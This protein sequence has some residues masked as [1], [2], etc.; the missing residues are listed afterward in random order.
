MI[1]KELE[2][3][4]SDGINTV[5]VIGN[6][7]EPSLSRPVDKENIINQL[8]KLGNT[9]FIVEDIDIEMN[10][11]IFV[12]L[13]EL[14]ELRRTLVERLIEK[15]VYISKKRVNM[16]TCKSENN[17]VRE[18]K[19]SA[20]V[21]NEEQLLTAL[22]EDLD[23][24]YITDINLYNKYNNNE[25]VYLRTDRVTNNFINY[26]NENILATELGTINKYSKDNNVCCDYYLNVNNNFSIKTLEKLGIKRICLSPEI[27]DFDKINSNIDIEMIIYGRL[28]LMITKYCPLNTLINKDD[29][30]C[31]LCLN[32]DRYYLK[33]DKNRRYPLIHN[34]HITHIMHHKNLNLFNDVYEYK[35]RG[36]NCF[37]LELFDENKDEMLCLISKLKG[38]LY[39]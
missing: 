35:N 7:I 8:F 34:K 10:N 3:S 24:I 17:I 6:K 27:K 39:E 20:L 33:D 36:V 14:N 4:I 21:R 15:R 19:I 11:N 32:K 5:T 12:S 1:D 2:I 30:K 22:K 26:S 16:L 37:R 29:K 18:Y 9:P 28:E 23:Y 25:N 31:N 38:A 13:K